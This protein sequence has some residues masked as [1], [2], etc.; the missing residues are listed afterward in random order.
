MRSCQNIHELAQ[1]A[2][3]KLDTLSP[4]DF[5]AFWST[6]PKILHKMSKQ[7]D[8]ELEEKLSSILGCTLENIN[9]FNSINISRTAWGIA[10]IINKLT[11]SKRRYHRNDPR[12]I[13]HYL[14]VGH[15]GEHKEFIF[16]CIET[17]SL[18][19]IDDF[20]SQSLSNLI[21]AFGLVKYAPTFDDG[22]SLFDTLAT[23]ATH[24]LRSFNGQDFSN[25]L[26]AYASVGA[27]N[28]R[29]FEETGNLIVQQNELGAFRPQALANIVWAYAKVGESH[30]EL[31]KK[32]GDHI[33][34]LDL[35]N[36]RFIP[37]DLSIIVWAYAT[38]GESHPILFKKLGDP[39]GF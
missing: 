35:H 17:S 20:D 22:R 23:A 36:C 15:N 13:L 26:L 14:L 6:A 32:I 31:F 39:R 28:P 8:P 38:I 34:V 7:S 10:K 5:A 9:S 12:Q 4:R 33:V 18:P 25:M 11:E 1:L 3:H 24:K 16:N 19:I 21:Y 29:L 2:Y 37:Q 27:K 30:L